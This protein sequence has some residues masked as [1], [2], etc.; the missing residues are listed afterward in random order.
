MYESI[1]H[2]AEKDIKEI[3][4]MVGKI[5]AGEADSEELSASI[6]ER[7]LNLG[8]SLQIEIY[9]KLDEEI[10]TSGSRKKNWYIERRGEPKELLDVMGAI[11]Y[12]RTGYVNKHTGAYAYL[13][14]Q[15]LGVEKHQRITLGSAANILEEAVAS[16]YLRGGKRASPEDAAS[17]Q[18]VKELVHRTEVKMP[19]KGAIEKKKRKYLHIIADEDHVSAQFWDRKGDLKEG[20][21][22]QKV[23]TIQAKLVCVYE[24]VINESGEKSKNPRYALT[25]KRYFSGVYTG[26]AENERLWREVAEYI[27]TTY[28]TRVLERIYS[29]GDGAAWIKMGVDVIENSCFV[30][31]KFHMMRYVDTSVAHL[32]SNATD[33]KE[34]IWEALN[35]AN[36]KLLREAYGIILNITENENKK[37]EA[38]GALKYFLN[39]WGG[40]RIRVKDAGG[41]WRCCAEGQVSHVLSDRL[42]SRPMGWSVLGC[43]QMAQ[44]R[45]YKRN[46]G[47][48]IDLLRYQ[49][50]KKAKEDHINRQEELI[51]ELRQRQNG[52]D[53]AERLNANIPGLEVHSMKWLKEFIHRE[54][55]IGGLIIND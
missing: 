5:L 42:S 43:D 54:D 28:D 12:R 34:L 20:A 40:I 21:A 13:L 38:V 45:A 35:T 19:E 29:A 30:L 1:L 39:N 41:C 26:A 51:K 46:G 50:K 7:V 3:E 16:S 37:E 31:D 8:K 25:G 6:H 36:K 53:Y 23:N 32:G 52:W 15:V 10:R 24:D 4:K 49:K 27:E 33:A 44:F 14:D 55:D 9:E 48:I 11:K 47:K 2:F 17:K 18:A 22:G